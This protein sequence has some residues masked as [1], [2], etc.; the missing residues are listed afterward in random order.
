[1][2]VRVNAAYHDGKPWWKRQEVIVREVTESRVT[3]QI[4]DGWDY[5]WP[6]LGERR[7]MSRDKF[8]RTFTHEIEFEQ[9]P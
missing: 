1:M 9:A 2:N 7:S 4:V 8:E 5:G 6:N 3:Y